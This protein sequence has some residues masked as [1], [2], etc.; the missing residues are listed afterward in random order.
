MTPE[1]Q[2]FTPKFKPSPSKVHK[3]RKIPVKVDLEKQRSWATYIPGE[4]KYTAP[5][6]SDLSKASIS[7]LQVAIDYWKHNRSQERGSGGGNEESAY[8]QP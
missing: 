6:I 7:F 8:F 5:E 4:V 2:M 3:K 1:Q